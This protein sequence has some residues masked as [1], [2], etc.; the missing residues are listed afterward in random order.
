MATITTVKNQT[1]IGIAMQ[2]YGNI[3]GLQELIALNDLEGKMVVP[4]GTENDVDV[5]ANLVEGT[6]LTYNEDSEY[7]QA[8]KRPNRLVIDEL[9]KM[10]SSAAQL[11]IDAI[12]A[13]GE[14]LSSIQKD[15]LDLLIFQLNDASLWS[16]LIAIYPMIGNTLDGCKYNIKNPVDSDAAFRLTF[17]NN[18]S[19]SGGGIAWNGI[20]Q[21]AEMHIT[22]SIDFDSRNATLGYY[23]L[24]GTGVTQA[25]W[26][27]GA[28]G[29]GS[30]RYEFG[31]YD[32]ATTMYNN[33]CS[34]VPVQAVRGADNTD[35][36]FILMRDD[37]N[38]YSLRNGVILDTTA[39]A[40]VSDNPV[41]LTLG[42]ENRVSSR[43]RFTECKAGF[44]FV[45]Q[46][47]TTAEAQTLSTII[48][49]F[50]TTLN[51]NTY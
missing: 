2:V 14:T 4:A 25:G 46:E 28:Y 21:Y 12:E 10:Y 19:V 51:K 5:A 36:M 48:N 50:M 35:G 1:L 24:T 6:V 39:A 37:T 15:A 31:I 43:V 17:Y 40:S 23:S 26:E 22:P 8:S 16:K 29:N 44:A 42:A 41:P 38:I 20:N 9:P 13:E 34:S 49:T 45:A 47:M 32:T 33:M 11:A 7:M 18:P 3:D 27:M 30:N